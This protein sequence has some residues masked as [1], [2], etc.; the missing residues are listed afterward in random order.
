[1]RSGLLCGG[2]GRAGAKLCQS[3]SPPRVWL[4]VS[5]SEGERAGGMQG[6]QEKNGRGET[7]GASSEFEGGY[8]RG[9]NGCLCLLPARVVTERRACRCV[10]L[11]S[12]FRS[13]STLCSRRNALAADKRVWTMRWAGD[14][15]VAHGR[16]PFVP[17]RTESVTSL[18][19]GVLAW[20]FDGRP[21]SVGCTPGA[22]S[23]CK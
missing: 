7:G 13:Y 14:W 8:G 18:E 19:V 1:M 23:A 6:R 12:A 3:I 20:C 9:R 11:G 16:P 21:W 17:F 4:G 15:R 2:P 22:L 10:G 5:V